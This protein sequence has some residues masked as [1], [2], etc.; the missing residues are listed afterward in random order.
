MSAYLAGLG[1]PSWSRANILLLL[2]LDIY[3][4]MLIYFRSSTFKTALYMILTQCEDI[5]PCF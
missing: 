5:T 4:V 1:L 3:S 2:D